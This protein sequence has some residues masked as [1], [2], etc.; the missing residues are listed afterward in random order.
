MLKYSWFIID[1]I[2][3]ISTHYPKALLHLHMLDQKS[4]DPPP[5]GFLLGC[6]AAEVWPWPGTPSRSSPLHHKHI[7]L[8]LMLFIRRYNISNPRRC[9]CVQ[10][11]HVVYIIPLLC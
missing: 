9:T 7:V 4:E 10:S 11:A 1:S 8:I 2:I 5:G 3:N 6:S